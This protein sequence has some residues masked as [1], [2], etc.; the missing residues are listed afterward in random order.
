MEILDVHQHLGL[1]ED[2]VHGT[3]ED[4]SEDPEVREFRTRTATMDRSG[5][6]RA[7]IGPGYQYLMPNGVADRAKVNDRLAGLSRPNI[8]SASPSPWGPSR[9][10]RERR[11]S[12]EVRRIK[13]DLGMVG[14][15]WAQPVAGLLRRF[16]VDAA[17]RPHGDR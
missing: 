3:V 12:K 14:V 15:L 17:L 1:I 16:A 9:L 7:I 2:F 13:R 10:A 11:R 4:E 6:H 8:R 5:I